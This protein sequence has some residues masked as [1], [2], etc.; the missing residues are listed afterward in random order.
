MR[1]RFFL[2]KNKILNIKSLKSIYIKLINAVKITRRGLVQ[3][4]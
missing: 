4:T 3:I 2:P 1:N